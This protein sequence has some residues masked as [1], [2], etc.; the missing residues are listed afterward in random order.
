MAQLPI[1]VSAGGINAAG[2]SAFHS[3]LMR[4]V[5]PSLSATEQSAVIDE[6]RALTSRPDASA[7]DLLNDS[8]IREIHPDWYNPSALNARRRRDD[9]WADTDRNSPVR[10]AGMLPTGFHPDALYKSRAHPRAL[11]MTVFA[12]SD[13][14]A[15]SG[16]D[17]NELRQ[18][19]A[20][21][22]VAVYAGNSIGQL[23]HQGFGGMLQAALFGKRVSSKQLPLGYPQM[24][25]D[26]VNAYVLGTLGSTGAVQ[27]ACASF[28]YNL[29]NACHAIKTGQARIAVVG[30]ADAPIVPEVVEGFRAMGALADEAGLR[31]IDGLTPEQ[32]V[33]W[34][35]ASRPFG[36]NCGF[37]IA[38]GAQFM[39]LMDDELV[40][41]TG[42]RVL[43]SVPGLFVNADGPKRSISA[44]GAGNYLT[45][46]KAA[47]LARTLFGETDMRRLF[48][49][50]HGT[51]TPQNRVTESHVL[52]Q[53]AQAMGAHWPVTAI[54]AFIGHSQGT[55]GGDQMANA[56]GSF[57]T[58]WLPG[59]QTTAALADDV[60][61]DGLDFVMQD[62]QMEMPPGCFLN[63]KGF[64]GNNATALLAGPDVT[65][66]MLGKRHDMTAWARR[67]EAVTEQTEAYRLRSA[68]AEFNVQ[69][70]FG[71]DVIDGN[72]IA[73]SD[74]ELRVPGW[75]RG[76]D[77]NVP[78]PFP[79]LKL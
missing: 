58:G 28:L 19:I 18:R 4:M 25:A 48:V 45:M 36:H 69:Y 33:D 10:S 15:A 79:D 26:F 24:P 35:R 7:E 74:Q 5:Y 32:T 52:S 73:I 62:R 16:L 6:L 8:L 39:L 54:K 78:H 44:P 47:G 46:A 38:E 65:K 56:L 13:M 42:A 17:W 20:P 50:A 3:D 57:A 67:N 60:H 51:S 76:V 21:D 11:Q 53:V 41:E 2:R 49:H 55:A 59:I 68:N 27:G 30:G 23:D 75:D 1:I 72:D 63:A 64:G 77:L 37:T 40:A 61:R 66:A 43:G 71:E 22:Q 14:M 9:M 29:A 31:A 34:R 70:H 12:A